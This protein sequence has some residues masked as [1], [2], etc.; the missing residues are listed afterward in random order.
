MAKSRKNKWDNNKQ[1]WV[2]YRGGR[3]T[4][5]FTKRSLPLS[6][7]QYQRFK[8][9]EPEDRLDYVPK[10]SFRFNTRLFEIEDRRHFH[11]EGKERQ[12]TDFRGLRVRFRVAGI[13]IAKAKRPEGRVW[14]A[15]TQ[16]YDPLPWRIQ[17]ERPE[18]VL[19]CVR[20]KIRREVMHAFAGGMGA[21][22][23]KLTHL[24]RKP[25]YTKYSTVRC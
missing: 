2:Q 7:Q 10:R 20:R 13:P 16:G 12:A 23:G 24:F 11:P 3:E 9:E 15:R 14:D 8:I 5:V 1:A 4:N 22:L 17:F 18:R 6:Q 19:L 25:K 21:K